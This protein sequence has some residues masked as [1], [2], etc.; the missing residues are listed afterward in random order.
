[1][2]HDVFRRGQSTHHRE[3]HVHRDYIRAQLLAE[4]DCFLSV[5]GLGYQ[6]DVGVTTQHFTEALS[7]RHGIFNE[8][9]SYSCHCYPANFRMHSRNFPW[10]NSP[11]T[12]Y[13]CAPT[14]RPRLKSS[15]ESRE[16]TRIDGMSRRSRSDRA[17]SM[18][19]NPSM[20]GIS[21]STRK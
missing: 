2:G 19:V 17:R 8:E 12:M 10:L 18:N 21:T 1:M 16:L 5:L 3:H 11:F 7:R 15:G 13:A 9:Y 14:S 20:P 6:I 4:L